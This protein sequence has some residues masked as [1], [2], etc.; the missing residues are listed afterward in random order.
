MAVLLIQCRPSA[1]LFDRAC[2]AWPSLQDHVSCLVSLPIFCWWPHLLLPGLAGLI[3]YLDK[4]LANT[5]WTILAP[6]NKAFNSTLTSMGLTTSALLSPS[7][8]AFTTAILSY[9][10]IPSGAYTTANLT[11]C[12]AVSTLLPGDGKLTFK[13]STAASN[14]SVTFV[15]PDKF[16]T[17]VVKPD[18]M[19]GQCVV[20]IVDHVMLPPVSTQLT[21]AASASADKTAG[22]GGGVKCADWEGMYV[23]RYVPSS[24]TPRG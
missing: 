22:A 20:H 10:I 17:T 9:H 7:K 19:V 11:D 12:I 6:T 23:P 15:T 18:I 1:V 8:R 3:G 4:H 16:R 2:S 21:E 5:T 14:C 24:P 13:V